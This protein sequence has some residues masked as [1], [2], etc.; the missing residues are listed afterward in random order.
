LWTDFAFSS[1]LIFQLPERPVWIDTR[2]YPFPPEQWERYIQVSDAGPGWEEIL[3]EEGIQLLMLDIHSGADL[4]AAVCSSPAWCEC[5]HDD[6]AVI[7]S[8]SSED[9][10]CR[11][12]IN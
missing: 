4:V 12:Q 7:F 10:P 9:A 1:Y 2:F 11:S 8:R 3:D 5:Y 6:V